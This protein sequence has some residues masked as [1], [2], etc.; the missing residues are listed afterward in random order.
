MLLQC[1]RSTVYRYEKHGALVINK[2]GRVTVKSI[3]EL[4]SQP[5]K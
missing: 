3:L 5:R 2:R 4:E 1:D